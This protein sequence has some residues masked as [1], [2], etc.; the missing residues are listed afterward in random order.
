VTELT[1]DYTHCEDQTPATATTDSG[2]FHDVSSYSYRLSADH[3]SASYNPPKYAY[4]KS[5]NSCTIQFEVPYDIGPKVLLYYRLSNFFQNHRRY[6]KSLDSDQLQGKYRSAADLNKSGDCKPLAT[7]SNGK[8]IY[9]CGLVA[10]SQFNGAR[11]SGAEC[12]R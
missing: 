9:P 6:V 5:S 8:V 11:C 12:T 1:I 4:I 2:A 3:T 10:N 7:D